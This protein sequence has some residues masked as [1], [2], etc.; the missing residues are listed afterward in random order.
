MARLMLAE[1]IS[2][3]PN[4]AVESKVESKEQTFRSEDN[5]FLPLS[6]GQYRCCSKLR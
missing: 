3:N 6:S 1:R 2:F 4:S 5:T